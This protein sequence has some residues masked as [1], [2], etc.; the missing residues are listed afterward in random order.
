MGILMPK[1]TSKRGHLT[2]HVEWTFSIVCIYIYV[3]V[4]HSDRDSIEQTCTF[5]KNN[6]HPNLMW[7]SIGFSQHKHE[8]TQEPRAFNLQTRIQILPYNFSFFEWP[9]TQDS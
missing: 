1:E 8:L 3:C 4:C 9:E 7:E 5:T 6:N 2:K